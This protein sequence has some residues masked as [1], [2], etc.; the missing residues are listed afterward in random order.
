MAFIWDDS[1][2][3]FIDEEDEYD[4]KRFVLVRKLF[5]TPNI[6]IENNNINHGSVC[7]YYLLFFFMLMDFL[8]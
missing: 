1:I 7:T 2:W 3:Q 8:D 6:K 4:A 5:V